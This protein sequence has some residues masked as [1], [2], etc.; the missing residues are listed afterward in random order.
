LEALVPTLLLQPILENAIKHAIAPFSRPGF[1]HVRAR[2]NHEMLHLR[3]QDNGPGLPAGTSVPEGA[4][5]GLKNVQARLL[6][7]HGRDHSIEFQT[8]QPQGLAV[9]IAIPFRTV[10]P[11][12]APPIS[13]L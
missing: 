8:G 1:I 11:H 9:E 5:I 6:E 3:V 12:E 4:G 10:P 7:L 2:R 13:R